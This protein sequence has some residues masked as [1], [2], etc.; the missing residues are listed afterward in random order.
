MN[1]PII[2]E[3]VNGRPPTQRVKVGTAT[4]YSK[5]RGPQAKQTLPD[6]RERGNGRFVS[7]SMSEQV[8]IDQQKI[9]AETVAAKTY[10]NDKAREAF[11]NSMIVQASRKAQDQVFKIE[12]VIPY[13]IYVGINR[14]SDGTRIWKFQ[15]KCDEDGNLE[16]V[17]GLF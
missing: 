7:V 10:T 2:L 6:G 14:E 3:H 16:R 12:G 4:E 8:I 15:V 5:A 1:K 17:G 9:F 11:R 13:L